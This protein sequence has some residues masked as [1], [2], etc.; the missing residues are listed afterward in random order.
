GD[1]F[2]LDEEYERIK[3]NLALISEKHCTPT[4]VF[5]QR[6]ASK[7]FSQFDRIVKEFWRQAAEHLGKERIV[8]AGFGIAGPVINGSVRATNLPW[9]VDTASLI[10]EL[11]VPH[12]V[13][14][15]DLGATGHSIE[16]LPPEDF[17]V[18]NPGKPEPGGT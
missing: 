2:F 6:F 12:V 4:P 14:L 18:L 10:K 13:L 1:H 17:C 11:N 15:N 5:K 9:I 8:S 7:E 16:H 3:F